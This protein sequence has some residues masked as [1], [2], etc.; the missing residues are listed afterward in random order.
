MKGV[1]ICGTGAVG[2][3]SV[4]VYSGSMCDSHYCKLLSVSLPV[5]CAYKLSGPDDMSFCRLTVA[6]SSVWCI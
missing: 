2:W 1:C 6:G 4:N 3:H 5:V